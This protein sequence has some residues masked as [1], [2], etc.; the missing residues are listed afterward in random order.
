MLRAAYAGSADP[1]IGH[2]E[3]G[4]LD[5]FILQVADELINRVDLNLGHA[6]YADY[7]LIFRDA[8]INN[9]SVI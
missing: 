2:A 8:L 7:Q 1:V 4:S 3:S 9:E 6:G 5:G